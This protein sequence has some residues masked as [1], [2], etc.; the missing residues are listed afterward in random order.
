MKDM[1]SFIRTSKCENDN[2]SDKLLRSS[3]TMISL[4]VHEG[5]VVIENK[6]LE[7]IEMYTEL[8]LFC[9]QQR[10]VVIEPT[11]H[12]LIELNLIPTGII[13][14]EILIFYKQY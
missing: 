6:V 10:N 5:N 4:N 11:T 12:I 7:Y 9:G 8:C 13:N 1:L 14:C 2:C 3:S